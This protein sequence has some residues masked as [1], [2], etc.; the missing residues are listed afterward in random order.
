MKRL[1]HRNKWDAYSITSSAINLH[2]ATDR[3]AERVDGGCCAGVAIGHAAAPP[4]K[5]T[6]SRRFIQ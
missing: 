6:K 3:Q 1:L 4:R 2:L 5:V